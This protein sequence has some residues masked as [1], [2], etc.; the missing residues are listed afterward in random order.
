MTAIHPAIL[1]PR[2]W[3]AMGGAEQH[4][5]ALVHAM[6]DDVRP[7]VAKVCSTSEHTTDTAYA[8]AHRQVWDDAGVMTRQLAPAGLTGH[9]LRALARHSAHSRISRGLFRKLA[10]YAIGRDLRRHLSNADLNHVIYNGFTPMAEAAAAS[11]KP[12]VFTPLA[13]T[14]KPE[15]TAWSSSGFKRLYARA[16]ALIAMTA[17]ERAWLI[18]RG[19]AADRTHVVPMA[20]LLDETLTPDPDGFRARHRLGDAPVILFL[21]RMEQYK[22]YQALLDARHDVWRRHPDAHF[23][24][25]G[26][27]TRQSNAAFQALEGESRILNL[28]LID[29]QEKQSALAACAMLAVPSTEESL[30]VV[31]LEAWRFSK[32]VIAART[33]VM[34]SVINEGDD[35]LLSDPVGWKLARA[36]SGLLDNPTMAQAMGED[37]YAKVTRRYTWKGSAAKLA[38]IYRSLLMR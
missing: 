35:G 27:G 6:P 21:G 7:S 22:G 1:A 12:F 11:P 28:G 31:Y 8:F 24:F 32:P 2:Y 38:E 5:R 26:S 25:A 13:H 29:D 9:A 19:A 23:V 16:D 15:G 17:Y 4:S 33:P 10:Q 14:A 36:I 18:D 3:P 30:G 20:P 34:A 37:G